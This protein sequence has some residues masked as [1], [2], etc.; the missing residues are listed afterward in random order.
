M[1]EEE[2]H[3][4]AN[5]GKVFFTLQ[6]GKEAASLRWDYIPAMAHTN[7]WKRGDLVLYLGNLKFLWIQ[8]NVK[9]RLLSTPYSWNEFFIPLEDYSVG[10]M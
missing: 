1:N 5:V 8:G 6:N 10:A 7:G 3:Y 2:E 9:R 4:P